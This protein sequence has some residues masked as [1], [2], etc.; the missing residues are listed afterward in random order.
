MAAEITY[1][2][3]RGDV[4]ASPYGIVS[5]ESRSTSASSAQSGATPE[6]ASFVSV[7]C[8][9]APVRIA[10]GA[11]PTADASSVYVCLNERIWLTSQTGWK[12]A[13]INA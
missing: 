7:V 4:T 3:G 12:L 10:Y 8:T 13:I 9:T 1:W 11:N 6:D 2:S 5:S